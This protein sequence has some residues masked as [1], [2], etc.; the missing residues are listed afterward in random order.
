MLAEGFRDGIGTHVPLALCELAVKSR[1]QG[2]MTCKQ[3]VDLAEE[4]LA[5]SQRVRQGP[6]LA[7]VLKELGQ[8][9]TPF[10][11]IVSKAE[12]AYVA[13]ARFIHRPNDM[14]LVT[15]SDTAIT[16]FTWMPRQ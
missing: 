1:S 7:D 14:L 3:A 5:T 11:Y 12:G 2:T 9:V 4:T 8:G 10:E 15:A 16:G 6:S 13:A